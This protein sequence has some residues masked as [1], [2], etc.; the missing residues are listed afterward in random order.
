MKNMLRKKH[1]PFLHYYLPKNFSG[2]SGVFS[3]GQHKWMPDLDSVLKKVIYHS[4]FYFNK[5]GFY[6]SFF[7]FYFLIFNQHEI[8]LSPKFMT[9]YNSQYIFSELPV[10]FH[11][12]TSIWWFISTMRMNTKKQMPLPPYMHKPNAI[13]ILKNVFNSKNDSKIWKNLSISL[14]RQIHWYSYR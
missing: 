7:I 5:K 13:I 1:V 6:S 4:M 10:Y 3:A 2:L 14:Y 11:I 8:V 12:N 9:D